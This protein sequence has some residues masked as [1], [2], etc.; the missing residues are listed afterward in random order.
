MIRSL[1][2][3]PPGVTNTWGG[4]GGRKRE[5]EEEGESE[6][7]GEGEGC[8]PG[9]RGNQ[10]HR[11][12]LQPS[13]CSPSGVAVDFSAGGGVDASVGASVAVGSAGGGVGAPEGTCPG[14]QSGQQGCCYN[15]TPHLI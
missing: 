11:G 13:G 14:W 15:R 6:G 7:E 8:A 3:G 4:E 2:R 10:S 1:R 5:G 12:S 9:Q